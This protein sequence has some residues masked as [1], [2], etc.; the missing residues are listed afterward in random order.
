MK[1]KICDESESPPLDPAMKPRMRAFSGRVT[2]LDVLNISCASSIC[3]FWVNKKHVLFQPFNTHKIYLYQIRPLLWKQRE[4]ER[5]RERKR[6]RER[7]RD[8]DF[9]TVSER[10]FF[11]CG[12]AAAAGW[13][14]GSVWLDG[15]GIVVCKVACGWLDCIAVCVLICDWP[16]CCSNCCWR[17]SLACCCVAVTGE[18]TN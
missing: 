14:W 7:E 11:C 12:A 3:S 9:L 6:H 2:L 17:L 5:E 4:R 18:T 15:F 8:R 10:P 1:N 13:D 16:S